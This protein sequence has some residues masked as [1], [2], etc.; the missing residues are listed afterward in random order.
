[1]KKIISS[2]LVEK[3]IEGKIISVEEEELYMYGICQGIT[4]IQNITITIIVGLFFG[5]LCSTITFLCCYVPLRSFS[6]GYHASSEKK[7]FWYSLI[8]IIVMQIYFI[9]YQLNYFDLFGTIVSL[10]IIF[11]FSPMQ[12]PNKLLTQNESKYYKTIINKIIFFQVLLLLLAGK[13][14]I[15]SIQKGVLFSFITE[16]ILLFLG[17]IVWGKVPRVS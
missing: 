4:I 11:Y 8:L 15:I 6:G 17:K 10:I 13:F 16:A 2:Y 14:N 3:L 9:Y 5:N 7:C 12:S 1:M